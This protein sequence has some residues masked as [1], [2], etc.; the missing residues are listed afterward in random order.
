MDSD[1]QHHQTDSCPEC[2]GRG[3]H[4]FYTDLFTATHPC[5]MCTEAFRVDEDST[6]V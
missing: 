5:S 1:N 3:Y 4:T 6:S 2:N